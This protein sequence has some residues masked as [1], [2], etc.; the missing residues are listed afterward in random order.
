M[1]IHDFYT[2]YKCIYFS[3][4]CVLIIFFDKIKV[5]YISLFQ[6]F[7]KLFKSHPNRKIINYVKKDFETEHN[8]YVN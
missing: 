8:D 3:L 2:V 7:L 1:T 5:L 4:I 6:S